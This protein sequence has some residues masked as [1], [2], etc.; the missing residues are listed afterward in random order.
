MKKLI[1][2]MLA[3]ILLTSVSFAA[4]T[5]TIPTIG[6]KNWGTASQNYG[7]IGYSDNGSKFRLVYNGAGTTEYAG[8]PACYYWNS[9]ND[10]TVT[11]YASGSAEAFA[12]IWYCDTT[13]STTITK[14]AYGWIQIGGLA[15][16]YVKGTVTVSDVLSPDGTSASAAGSTYLSKLRGVQNTFVTTGTEEATILPRC[17]E[18]Y[19][20]GTVAKK[21]VL[22]RNGM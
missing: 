1:G 13:G 3:L 8:Q 19:A 18:T 15:D 10:Y 17:S 12:G 20:S 7:K 16:A 6:I 2:A 9:S 5:Q 4:V 22:L 14:A 11:D 21:K